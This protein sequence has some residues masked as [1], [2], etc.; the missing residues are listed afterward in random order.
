MAM[1]WRKIWSREYSV[2]YCETALHA[3]GKQSS[4]LL[5]FVM[6]HQLMLPSHKNELCYFEEEEEK[7]FVGALVEH[8]S[9]SKEA[10]AHFVKTFYSLGEEYEEYCLSVRKKNVRAHSEQELL[11]LYLIYKQKFLDYT[12]ILWAGYLLAEYW[13]EKGIIGLTD[14]KVK[15]ALFRPTKKSTVLLMQEEAAALKKDKLEAF[16]KKYQWLPCLDL[17]N[18]PWTLDDVRAYV[19]DITLGQTEKG[20][21]FEE[22]AGRAGLTKEQIAMYKMIKELAYIK[23]VRDD[24]RRKSVFYIRDLFVEIGKRLGLSLTETAYLTE[25]E[26]VEGLKG[27]AVPK[28]LA[29]KRLG[30]SLTE[31]AYLTEQEIVEGLKGKAVP[32][33]LAVKRQEGFLIY[34]ENDCIVVIDHAIDAKLKRMG[35]KEEAPHTKEL[36][37]ICAYPGKV[38]GIVKIVRTVHD[39]LKVNRGDVLVALTTHPDYV[40]AM[41]KAGAIVTDEGGMLSHAAIVSRELKIPCV[42]GTKSATKV[43]QHGTLVEV[44]AS[45][46]SIKPLS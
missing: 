34:I 15:E 46:G 16:W 35:F 30:L 39:I 22:A 45:R 41:Q 32:K 43:L 5:P 27:K 10:F 20:L 23:D 40:P 38:R 33:H 37:G 14:D 4:H 31:T 42:V 29:V 36:K 21:S 18:D 2:Q 25:Q 28:H 17:Q 7:K 3:L 44:D 19:S 13:M 1:R 8:Y 6:K 11:D 24:F 9:S 12:C 26:I